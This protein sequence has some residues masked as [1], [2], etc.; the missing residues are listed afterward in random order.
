MY[1]EIVSIYAFFLFVVRFLFPALQDSRCLS[2]ENHPSPYISF[3]P[4]PVARA[5]IVPDNPFFTIPA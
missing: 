5:T 3:N 2:K 4:C 1:I